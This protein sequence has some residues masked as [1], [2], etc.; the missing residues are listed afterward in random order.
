MK[1][2]AFVSNSK[3]LELGIGRV[4]QSDGRYITVYFEKVDENK[5]YLAQNHYLIQVEDQPK[6]QR[7]VD[8][9]VSVPSG[10][11]CFPMSLDNR[12]LRDESNACDARDY[13]L[14][15]LQ[16]F[17]T[18]FTVPDITKMASD[19]DKKKLADK[20]KEHESL[21][22]IQN[23]PFHAMVEVETETQERNRPMIR[24]WQLFYANE[25]A[26]TNLPLGNGDNRINILSWTHPG[27]Q[28]AMSY[29]LREEIDINDRGYTLRSITPLAR[30]KFSQIFPNISGLY[31]PGGSV[32]PQAQSK[33]ISGLKAIKLQ[34]TR[35]Q[36]GA[37]LSKM[38]GMMLVSGAPGSGKT[39]VAMQRIRFL[40][41]QQDLRQDDLHAVKYSPELTRI[42]LANENL[43]T[44][45]K[46]ML[47]KQL[48]IPSD[49]V[50]LV[51]DFIA[52]YLNNIW[53]YKH[54]AVLRRK[55]LF[56]L[57]E[58]GRQAFFGLCDTR[59]LRACW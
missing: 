23:H 9:N 41:D 46:E 3:N 38:N 35:E 5:E 22:A 36:V 55:K 14:K 4:I 33:N 42:F 8:M 58:R 37:F 50:K 1:E 28:L 16:G 57:E 34:M 10:K 30:A 40:Y 6:E 53:V 18:F 47:E 54:N 29:N 59:Q 11:G 26:N 13:A 27:I 44:Y 7:H 31:E 17:T 52:E 48:H 20:K 51:S 19:Y 24:K 45:S 49:V 2:G 12:V 39:T 56:F 21:D 25:H 32:R 15:A 43:I